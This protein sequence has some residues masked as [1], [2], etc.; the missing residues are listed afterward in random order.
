MKNYLEDKPVPITIS[1]QDITTGEELPGAHLELK[2]EEG[3]VIYAWVSDSV[4]FIIKDVLIA[5]KP[6]HIIK[7]A[8]IIALFFFIFTHTIL[9]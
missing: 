5:A 7:I 3:E 6:T 9:Y 1:K 8:T 4:P 2:D